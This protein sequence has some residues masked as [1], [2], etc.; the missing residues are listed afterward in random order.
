VDRVVSMVEQDHQIFR[1]WPPVAQ[2]T[3]ER[4][5]ILKRHLGFIAIAFL[6]AVMG[7]ALMLGGT[8]YFAPDTIPHSLALEL[9]SV[10]IGIGIISI[11]IDVGFQTQLAQ[12]VFHAA[13]G[14]NI[15]KA[16]RGQLRWIY[17]L[18]CI[19]VSYIHEVDIEHIQGSNNYVLVKERIS[20]T[21][22]PLGDRTVKRPFNGSI[23]E[24]FRAGR[25]SRITEARI[26][27]FPHKEN[28]HKRGG[29]PLVS[30]KS[31]EDI[32]IRRNHPVTLVW[33]FETVL[34]QNDGIVDHFGIAA[35]GAEV[36]VRKP[37]D[38]EVLV[39]FQ[40]SEQGRLTKIGEGRYKLDALILPRQA[41]RV[42]WW[43]TED[44]KDWPT[45]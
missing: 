37:D 44:A 42:Q 24:F 18:D 11:G 10:L 17:E 31:N 1:T 5:P 28:D 39:R 33:S 45:K 38:L 20:R 7:I 36:I 25:N 29:R 12:N 13:F 9:G 22:E 30:F 14:Y 32:V 35:K 21:V 8:A 6:I 23:R 43:S 15:D 40:N 19:V 2:G 4:D 27:V 16:L 41:I 3:E 26:T 34:M